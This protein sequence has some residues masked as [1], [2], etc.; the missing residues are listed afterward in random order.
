MFYDMYYFGMNPIWWSVWMLILF[1]IFV[2][3]Y[4]IPGQRSRTETPFELLQKRFATGELSLQEYNELKQ[5]FK[6]K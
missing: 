5:K 3:P 4:D 2:T 6:K 1:W